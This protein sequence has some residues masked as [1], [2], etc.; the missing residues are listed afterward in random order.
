MSFYQVTRPGPTALLLCSARTRPASLPCPEVC[1][2]SFV[3]STPSRSDATVPF[4]PWRQIPPPQ[5]HRNS[6][7]Q[8]S[9]ASTRAAQAEE[10]AWLALAP[11]SSHP[12]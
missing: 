9:D 2:G 12:A 8:G 7:L 6:R 1:V 11:S 10:A 3:P 4:P 5:P